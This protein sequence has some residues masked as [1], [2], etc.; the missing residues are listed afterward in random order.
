MTAQCMEAEIYKLR[1]TPSVWWLGVAALGAVALG[2]VLTLAL[3]PISSDDDV[4]SLMSFVGTGGLVTLLLGV[5]W[6]AGE[7]R[8]RTIVSTVLATPRRVPAYLGQIVGLLAA[9]AVIGLL[10]AVL[11]TMITLPWLAAKD[12]PFG[13][14]SGTVLAQYAGGVAFTALSAGIGGGIGAL[15]RNQVAAAAVLFT[16]LAIVDPMVASLVP[17]YGKY[18]VTSISITLS[19]GTYGVDGQGGSLLPVPAAAAVYVACAAILVTAGA[20]AT[21]RRELP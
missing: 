5:V 9:G 7:Y 1:R 17:S 18:G 10:C 20:V 6:T 4:R 21:L 19:G 3:A 11:T 8:H 16:Y 2:L 15:V 14:S 13:V 12:V